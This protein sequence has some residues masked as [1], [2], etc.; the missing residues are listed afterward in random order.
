MNEREEQELHNQLLAD[1]SKRD[2]TNF[3]YAI[4]VL[5]EG[6]IMPYSIWPESNANAAGVIDGSINYDSL[7]VDESNEFHKGFLFQE[8]QDFI[9]ENNGKKALCEARSLK[10]CLKGKCVL[11]NA[12]LG[13]PV[14]REYKIAFKK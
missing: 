3:S 7:P 11:Y 12:S 5:L 1:E 10:P 13:P 9:L 2:R 4:D 8:Q 6:A 14:C